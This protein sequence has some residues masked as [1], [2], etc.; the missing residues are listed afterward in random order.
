MNPELILITEN[1]SFKHL[2]DKSI[3]PVNVYQEQMQ[4]WLF[5]PVKYLAD[6]HDHQTE[7]RFSH[8]Y[9]V[10]ALELLFFEPHGKYLTG[11]T[12]MTAS[13]TFKTGFDPFLDFLLKNKYVE[14]ATFNKIKGMNFYDITRCGIYHSLT[15]K[16]KILIDSRK[17]ITDKVFA[18]STADNGL[19]VYPW[20]FIIAL[21]KYFEDYLIQVESNIQ[22][23]LNKNF[24][25]TFNDIFNY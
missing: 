23:D 14:T 10:F 13:K 20:N 7:I 17:N 3:S 11:N 4:K 24:H 6:M 8:G 5:L 2:K 1:I 12:K 16:S 15:I 25:K 22:C 9:S 18:N 21:E 19:F